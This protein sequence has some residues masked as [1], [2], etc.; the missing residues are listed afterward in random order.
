ML[1]LDTSVLVAAL[2]EDEPNHEACLT[3]LRRKALAIWS[4]GL[5]E[6]FSTLT[7][8]RLGLRLAPATAS[9]L[10]KLSLVPRLQFVELTV[11][12]I[13]AA[14]NGAEAA[15]VRGGGIYDFLHLQAARKSDATVLHT[16]NARHFL[17][18]S[19]QGDPAIQDP[20]QAKT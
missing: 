3:L 1:Y 9:E 2:I 19:G 16:L 4:H 14:I 20:S 6:V 11:K 5:T 7:G 13:L 15:G 17:A 18:L 8:G 12:E 10:I